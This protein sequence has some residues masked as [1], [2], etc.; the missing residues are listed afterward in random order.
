MTAAPSVESPQLALEDR[1]I[2]PMLGGQS[3]TFGEFVH[4]HDGVGFDSAQLAAIWAQLYP[5][6]QVQPQPLPTSSNRQPQFISPQPSQ[7]MVPA[8]LVESTPTTHN[9]A[10]LRVFVPEPGLR[11]G[12]QLAFT[13]PDAGP[14]RQPLQMRV[15]VN[16]H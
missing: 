1:R 10:Q 9:M 7:A 15:T 5:C 11:A 14:G 16:E 3:V 4:A 12:Q 6:A 2:D 8:Q 13:A